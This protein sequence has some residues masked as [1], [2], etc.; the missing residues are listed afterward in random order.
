MNW[1]DGVIIMRNRFLKGCRRSIFLKIII[2]LFSIAP[3]GIGCDLKGGPDG[4]LPTDEPP[5]ARFTDMGDGTVQDIDT[6]LIWLKDANAFGTMS[7]D[8]A[9]DAVVNL[10]SG[11]HGL[12]DES[13]VGDWRLPT[14]EEWEEFVDRSYYRPPLC[15]AQRNGQ[16][17][18]GDAFTG[19]QTDKSP[20]SPSN[21]ALYWSSTRHS[22]G[23]YWACYFGGY[24]SLMAEDEIMGYT[25]YTWPVRNDN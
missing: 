23:V 21:G 1:R 17:S 3:I 13:A 5:E 10:S 7:W 2:V 24:G 19:V 9:M 16:W 14:K 6:G 8:D 25:Q 22:D 18:E 4:P 20:G 11:D 12:T 15:N